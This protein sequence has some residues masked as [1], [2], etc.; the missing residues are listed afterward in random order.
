VTELALPEVEFPGGLCQFVATPIGN[1]GD[2]SLRG[3][4]VLAAADT[5]LAEDTRRTRRLLSHYGIAAH[6]ES[7]HDHNKARMVPRVVARLEAGERI[8]VVT[9]AGMPCVSDPGFALVRALAAAD[10]TWTVVPGPSSVL[11]ALVLSGLPPDRFHFYGYAP[12][13]SGARR[14]FL[15]EALAETG[16]VI[17]LE[18]CHRIVA[19]LDELGRLAPDSQT[20]VAREITKVHEEVLRGTPSEVRARMKGV[21]L[22]GELVLL[23]TSRDR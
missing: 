21:R 6:L 4:A 18:S 15:T 13:K 7:Y 16:T 14:K 20:V 19:T 8:A 5:V 3:L 11:A 22:K 9:D 23:F 2:M 1:L 10:L 17:V 12:R